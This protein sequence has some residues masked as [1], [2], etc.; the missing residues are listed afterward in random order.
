MASEEVFIRCIEQRNRCRG[1]ESPPRLTNVSVAF[2]IR[3]PCAFGVEDAA[4]CDARNQVGL[5]GANTRIGTLRAETRAAIKEPTGSSYRG[6]RSGGQ[7]CL[8]GLP[9]R[10]V[11][12]TIGTLVGRT[13]DPTRVSP[14]TDGI[15]ISVPHRDLPF[16]AHSTKA[17]GSPRGL[18]TLRDQDCALFVI[19]NTWRRDT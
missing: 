16:R 4:Q 6:R 9:L 15:A 2:S 8:M 14:A 12:G 17:P 10:T 3:P 11:V 19:A 1:D 18:C 5:W 13:E 7:V